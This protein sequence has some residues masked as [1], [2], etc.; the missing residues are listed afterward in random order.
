MFTLL[1]LIVLATTFLRDLDLPGVA[2]ELLGDG[3]EAEKHEVAL[4][5]LRSAEH[6]VCSMQAIQHSKHSEVVHESVEGCKRI[7][8][9]LD[10]G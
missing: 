7:N 1:D 4:V 6:S 10:G 3:S 8:F 9:I 2:G 5:F